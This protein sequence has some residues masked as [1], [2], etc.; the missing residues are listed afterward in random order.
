MLKLFQISI[1]RINAIREMAIQPQP[2]CLQTV[3]DMQEHTA[4]FQPGLGNSRGQLYISLS[5]QMSS[6]RFV[7]YNQCLTRSARKADAW[8]FFA[9]MFWNK[10]DI[11]H[12]VFETHAQSTFISLNYTHSVPQ[13][14]HSIIQTIHI[15]SCANIFYDLL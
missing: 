4:M 1:H 7:S 10:L 8:N 15:Q 5:S 2:F 14:T 11:V 12:T 3:L 9:C 13:C 6:L